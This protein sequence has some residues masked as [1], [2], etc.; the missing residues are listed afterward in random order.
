[1][2]I[3]KPVIKIPQNLMYDSV[4][5]Y[6][7]EQGLKLIHQGK[8]R[9]TFKLDKERLLVLVTDRVSIFDFVLNTLIP[10]KGEVLTAQ[11]LFWAKELKK[12]FPMLQTHLIQ[13][14]INPLFNAAYD[15]K[16]DLPNLPTERCLVVKNL[17]GFLDPFELIFRKHIGGSIYGDYQKKQ[18]S[19]RQ[20]TSS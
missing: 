14:S 11:T 20:N 16:K 8:V 6:L 9:N 13:S 15:L 3:K 2:L 4:T 1:M 7:Q 17:K 19:C 5:E 12:A 10:Y 18:S